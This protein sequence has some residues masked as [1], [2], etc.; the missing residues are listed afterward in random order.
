MAALNYDLLINQGETW[1][2]AFPVMD[3]AGDPLVVNGWSARAQI[4]VYVHDT[5]PLFEW[6]STTL[7]NAVVSGTSVVL[8]LDPVDTAN[9]SF[10]SA[11]YDI[12]LTD[13]DGAVTR[14]AEGKVY[15]KPEITR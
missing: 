2:V 6:N 9:W 3:G 14:L 12:E 13:P 8:H 7:D 5:V 4:R 10:K 1:S 11:L 15:L